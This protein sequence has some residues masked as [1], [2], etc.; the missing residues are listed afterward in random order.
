[1]ITDLDAFTQSDDEE[2][3]QT[4][5]VNTVLLDKIRANVV[6]ASTPPTSQALVL[7]RPLAWAAE[8]QTRREELITA[9]KVRVQ[10]D[11]QT[12]EEDMAMDVEL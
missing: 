12:D 10:A 6:E 5:A 4:L 1:V 8:E 7:F 11:L 2:E 3:G 9:H